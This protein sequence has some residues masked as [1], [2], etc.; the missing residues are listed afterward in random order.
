MML[1]GTRNEAKGI[2]EIWHTPAFDVDEDAMPLAVQ[3]LST[4]ALDLLRD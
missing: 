4:A 3:M 2:K 1:L